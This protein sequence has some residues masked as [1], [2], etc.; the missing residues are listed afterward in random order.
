[1]KSDTRHSYHERVLNVLVHIQQ[2]LDDELPLDELA[3]VAHFSPYHFH[4]MF[5][6]MVGESVEEHV[7]RL[8]LER[9]A[10][11]RQLREFWHRC[12][13]LWGCLAPLRS[14]PENAGCG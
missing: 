5:R 4:R 7:R 13:K 3:A 14:P 10:T 8:R 6:G 11:S 2:H 12:Q 1:M 9:A